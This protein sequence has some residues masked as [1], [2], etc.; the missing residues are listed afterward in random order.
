MP[1][2]QTA[3]E[4]MIGGARL[5]EL[6]RP[7]LQEFHTREQRKEFRQKLNN[8]AQ[9]SPKVSD[10]LYQELTLDASSSNDNDIQHRLKLI[11]MGETELVDDLRKFNGRKSGAFDEYFTKIAEVVEDVTAADERRHGMAH[12]SQFLTSV[13]KLMIWNK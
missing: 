7:Q 12:F 6:C 3:A 10:F 9:V 11:Y 2:N 5:V 13:P 8:I 1:E 4:M